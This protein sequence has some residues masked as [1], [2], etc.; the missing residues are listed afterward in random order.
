MTK[1][2]L[3]ERIAM[4]NPHL[5][6]SDVERLV[7]TVLN[8]IK[9]AL[10]EGDRVELR[11]FGVFTTRARKARIARNPKTG[12][13]VNVEQKSIPYFKA[14]KILKQRINKKG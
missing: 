2:E 3:I 11:G 6:A 5:F 1:S 4:N 12:E 14:G 13:N 9:Q 7:T 10:A 8:R